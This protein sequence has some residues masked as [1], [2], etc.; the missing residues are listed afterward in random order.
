M[1]VKGAS[2]VL[3]TSRIEKNN[4]N[5]VLLLYINISMRDKLVRRLNEVKSDDDR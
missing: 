2:S 5:K 1:C 3:S 4:D